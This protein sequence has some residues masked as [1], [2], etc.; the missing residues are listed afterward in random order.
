MLGGDQHC[1]EEQVRGKLKGAPRGYC[2]VRTKKQ[3]YNSSASLLDFKPTMPEEERNQR[4]FKERTSITE[5]DDSGEPTT[6]CV[7][8]CVRV[9]PGCPWQQRPSPLREGREGCRNPG[10]RTRAE[11]EASGAARD[12]AREQGAESVSSYVGQA[13]SGLQG[14]M[15][16]HQGDRNIAK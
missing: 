8:V 6:E 14:C 7:S 1:M 11:H 5:I 15:W 10:T 13:R 9:V 4:H 3:E 16:R 2:G 12:T